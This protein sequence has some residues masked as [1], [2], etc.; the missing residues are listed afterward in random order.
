MN[1]HAARNPELVKFDWEVLVS[2]DVISDSLPLVAL[3]RILR[4]MYELRRIVEIK[5]MQMLQ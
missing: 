4:R 1:T 3:S 2:F 5:Y